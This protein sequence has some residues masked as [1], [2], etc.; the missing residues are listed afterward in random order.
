MRRKPRFIS[1]MHPASQLSHS[2]RVSD[3]GGDQDENSSS[4]L[5]QKEN[6]KDDGG[7][8]VTF[9]TT[10]YFSYT[11]DEEEFSHNCDPSKT[12]API[13][14]ELLSQLKSPLEITIL[15]R[16]RSGETR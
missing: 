8:H 6:K 11:Q 2:P 16:R 12:P 5:K 9:G 4:T 10:E 7:K 1:S 3:S 14:G 13:R 15:K